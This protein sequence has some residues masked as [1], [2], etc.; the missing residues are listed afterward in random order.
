M[1]CTSKYPTKLNEVGLNVAKLFKEKF[2]VRN[3]ISDHTGSIYP[4]LEAIRQNF[5]LIEVH[6]E[7]KINK[8]EGPDTNSS[9]NFEE[10]KI[11]TNA[12][13]AYNLINNKLNKDFSVKSISKNKLLFTKSI[14]TKVNVSK[15]E[16]ITNKNI[17]FKK[18]GSG[19]PED[20]FKK[21]LNFKF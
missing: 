4:S 13:R 6:V 21:I 12:N 16:R 8:Q 3:G 15:G 18:P 1:Q 19:I 7:E 5:D 9:I 20:K 2:K 17:C 14:C 10:L 11:L